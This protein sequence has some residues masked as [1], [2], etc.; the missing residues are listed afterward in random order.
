MWEHTKKL[1][2]NKKTPKPSSTVQ[3]E[4][5]EECVCFVCVYGTCVHERERERE[6]SQVTLRQR[7]TQLWNSTRPWMDISK[8]LT[9]QFWSKT[10][11]KC[12]VQRS[13]RAWSL[14]IMQGMMVV[15]PKL[16]VFTPKDFTSITTK[17]QALGKDK[18]LLVRRT[19]L[20]G[21]LIFVIWD[22]RWKGDHL[23]FHLAP[24]RGQSDAY[25]ES[26]RLNNVKTVCAKPGTFL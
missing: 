14:S 3:E 26:Y 22:Q 5:R 11:H 10:L 21:N 24:V 2:R 7:H 17:K 1:Q 16:F 8:D 4:K 6:R 12:V 18:Q 25:Q 23:T 19:T 15:L 9:V 13:T 20:Q